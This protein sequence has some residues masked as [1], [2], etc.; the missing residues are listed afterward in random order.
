ML[1]FVFDFFSLVEMV[2]RVPQV[3][4]MQVF[5]T[6][7]TYSCSIV[8]TL[9]VVDGMLTVRCSHISG[10]CCSSLLI[11]LHIFK[12]SICRASLSYISGT[13]KCVQSTQFPHVEL[14]NFNE[15]VDRTC[16]NCSKLVH[17]SIRLFGFQ[18]NTITPTANLLKIQSLKTIALK[19]RKLVEQFCFEFHPFCVCFILISF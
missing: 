12:Q 17:S 13:Q 16:Y 9:I 4:R 8:D 19:Q 2:S 14:K 11:Q 5:F 3:R 7:F 15:I 18:L 10:C 6:S 1:A